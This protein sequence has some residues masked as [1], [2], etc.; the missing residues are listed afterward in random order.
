MLPLTH[1]GVIGNYDFLHNDQ[2]II[3][4]ALLDPFL[5]HADIFLG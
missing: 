5:Q 1:P 2:S 4:G 3:F